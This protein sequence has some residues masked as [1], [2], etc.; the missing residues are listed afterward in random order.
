MTSEI[1]NFIVEQHFKYYFEIDI[2]LNSSFRMTLPE[3]PRILAP[4][5]HEMTPTQS[6]ILMQTIRKIKE[7]ISRMGQ[8]HKDLHSTV[9]KV[10]K[11]VDRVRK[12]IYFILLRFCSILWRNSILG[13]QPVTSPAWDASNFFCLESLS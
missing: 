2:V 10:G 13:Q 12:G 1:N 11:S 6:L 5:E 4:E 9:S 8:E 7:A 3:L